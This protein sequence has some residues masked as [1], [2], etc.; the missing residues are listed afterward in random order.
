MTFIEFLNSINSG[1][2]SYKFTPSESI[3]IADIIEKFLCEVE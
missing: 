3:A 1:S 2:S